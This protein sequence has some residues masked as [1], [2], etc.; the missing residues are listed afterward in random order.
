MEEISDNAQLLGLI[1]ARI[2][3]LFFTAPVLSSG[4]IHYRTRTSLALFFAF[5]LYPVTVNDLPSLPSTAQGY[6]LEVFSQTIIGIT[7]GFMVLIIFSAFQV[8]GQ[9]LSLQMGISFSEVLDPQ[10][11]VSLPLLGT[12]K[13]SI[14]ILIFLAV[15]FQ[16]DG[17]YVPAFLHMIRALAHSFV[18][19]P[20]LFISEQV[21]GGILNYMEQAFTMMFVIALKIGIPL[22][23]IL[24]ISSLTLGLMGKAAPQM[25]L[26]S[27]G[28]QVN[29]GVGIIVL[30]FLVPVIVP[31][32]LDAFIVLY[33]SMGEMLQ[34]WPQGKVR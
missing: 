34:T 3:G 7:L 11:Q 18:N 14:G 16:M 28:I 26:M 25:N 32:M 4:A 10:S 20:T 30:I 1:L 5:I 2:F 33:D 23:G 9:M 13:N 24:F 29:I 22:I 17:H 19:V 8:I 12:F 21:Q 6:A 27:M 31:L 15:P